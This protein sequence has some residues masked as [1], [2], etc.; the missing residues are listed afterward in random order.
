MASEKSL[1]NRDVG[2]R[3]IF[4]GS[5]NGLN[6]DENV[7]SRRSSNTSDISGGHMY[8]GYSQSQNPK[9]MISYS[10]LN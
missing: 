9:G 10:Y 5:S 6:I 4:S 3:R 1:V 2:G 8:V 7:Y